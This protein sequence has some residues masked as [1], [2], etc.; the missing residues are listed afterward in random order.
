[1]AQEILAETEVLRLT[2]L[3]GISLITLYGLI[4]SWQWELEEGEKF[5]FAGCDDQRAGCT[6]YPEKGMISARCRSC[7]GTRM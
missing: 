7:S 5:V 3:C 1:M 6:R 4:S 2:R